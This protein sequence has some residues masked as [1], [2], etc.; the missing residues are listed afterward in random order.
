MIWRCILLAWLMLAPAAAHAQWK[1]ATSKH[2]IVYSEGSD[3]ELKAAVTDLEKYDF[4]LRLAS[5]V[6]LTANPPRFRIYLMRDLE[7]VQRTMAGGGGGVAGYYVASSRGPLA[8]GMRK[9][10]SDEDSALGAQ[11]VLFHEYAHHF[12]FQYFPAAYPA[13]YS[14]G[15]AEYYGTTKIRGDVMEVGRRAHHRCYSF[16]DDE[17]LPLKKVLTAK[18]YADVAGAVHLFYAEGWLLVHYLTHNKQRSGQLQAYLDAVN[19]GQPYKSA[20]DKAFGP[21][22]EALNRELRAYSRKGS[23]NAVRIPFKPID[24]G[25]LS[26]RTLSPAEQALVE[27]DITL[28]RGL[29][30]REAARFAEDVRAV[31]KRFPADPY[32]LK[33]LAEAERAVGNMSGA[34]S[35]VDRWLQVQPRSPRGLM[36]K[37]GIQI[38]A[39]RE[40]RS[41]D[42]KAWEDARKLLLEAHKADTRDPLILET[43]YDSFAA[44]GISPPAGA[45][46]ALFRALELVPQDSA[47]RYKL[48]LDFEQRG[49]IEDA[50]TIIKPAAFALHGEGEE[51]KR[52]KQ[53]RERAERK[54]REVGE[55]KTETAREMLARLE[56]KL[57]A[58]RPSGPSTPPGAPARP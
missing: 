20:M 42:S 44:Q 31:A 17:W 13:W 18:N 19:A 9:D 37:A 34:T 15:F 32:A 3:A 6:S 1:E 54:W 27:K 35:A 56:Q 45:Q 38:D 10:I 8:V 14:E 55:T 57:A 7:A 23:I 49:L 26:V 53:R 50:I 33:I 48:A 36:H 47:I 5:K 46:N 12:M 4:L 16:A 30:E 2:F 39:L 58:N 43:Y 24:V 41:Q 25:A 21:D 52:Q 11:E 51:S 22:A 28:G 29:Y 40:A